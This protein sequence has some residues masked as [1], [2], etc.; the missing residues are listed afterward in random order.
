KVDLAQLPTA[1]DPRS[2]RII[3][4]FPA[5]SILDVFSSVYPE[6]AKIHPEWP[7]CSELVNKAFDREFGSFFLIDDHNAFKL[8]EVRKIIGT[9]ADGRPI[10]QS[11]R[12]SAADFV[13]A[14]LSP[15][16]F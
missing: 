7:L 10:V 13:K 2:E 4:R 15:G 3:Y 11:T 12:S 1:H 9:T 16:K 5:S 14:P 8:S 6:E